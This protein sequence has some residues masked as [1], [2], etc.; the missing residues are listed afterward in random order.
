MDAQVIACPQCGYEIPLTEAISHRIREELEREFHARMAAQRKEL[1]GRE[2][3]LL[4]REASLQE[5]ARRMEE[6]VAKRLAQERW[7]FAVPAPSLK[8]LD[9]PR[10]AHLRGPRQH[11]DESDRNF[12]QD[13]RRIGVGN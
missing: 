10:I 9:L 11:P 13:R 5:D 1:E 2:K 8:H 12:G 6:E 4:S 3:E 7:T